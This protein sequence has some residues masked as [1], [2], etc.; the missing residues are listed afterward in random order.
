MLL[1]PSLEIPLVQ[2][3]LEEGLLVGANPEVL[4]LEPPEPEHEDE[5]AEV[6]PLVAEDEELM[7]GEPPGIGPLPA[8][9][10]QLIVDEPH[11]VGPLHAEDEEFV[12]EPDGVGPLMAEEEEL[13]DEPDGVGP[14]IAE[15]EE[16]L[17][18]EPVDGVGPLMAG[19]DDLSVDGMEHSFTSGTVEWEVRGKVLSLCV[20]THVDRV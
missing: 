15:D 2:A 3:A 19:D 14:W 8:E 5:P 6:G 11:G 9:D 7:E 12:D 20:G 17:V 16:F 10:G 1:L 18:D 13:V 4:P